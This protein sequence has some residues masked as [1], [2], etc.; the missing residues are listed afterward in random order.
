M[1]DWVNN[2]YKS[3]IQKKKSCESWDSGSTKME[4]LKNKKEF[5]KKL[6]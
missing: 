1:W 4:P 6:F 2:L 3:V 5:L